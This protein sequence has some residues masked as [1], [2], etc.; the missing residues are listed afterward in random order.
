MLADRVKQII[1]I[2]C[3]IDLCDEL[4]EVITFLLITADY[5]CP[6]WEFLVVFIAIWGENC[7]DW[8]HNLWSWHSVIS[9]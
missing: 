7:K 5:D 2:Q 4:L 9:L 8:T 6:D 1:I 3:R